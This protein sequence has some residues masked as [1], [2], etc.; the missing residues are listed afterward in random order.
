MDYKTLIGLFKLYTIYLIFLTLILQSF[1]LYSIRWNFVPWGSS[2]HD[3]LFFLFF[4][5]I[6]LPAIIVIAIL[7]RSLFKSKSASFFKRNSFFI[8][9]LLIALPS[10]DAY[11]SQLALGI[12]SSACLI[13]CVCILIEF[14]TWQ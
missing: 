4:Y 5:F 6:V 13:A 8:Y 11:G 1:Y 7:K 14:F 12:G 9:T 3:G 2:I 10:I